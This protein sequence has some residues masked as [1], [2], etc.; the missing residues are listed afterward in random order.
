MGSRTCRLCGKPLSRIRVGSGDFCSREHHNQYHLRCGMDRMLEVNKVASLMRRCENP[1]PLALP[2]RLESSGV[3]QRGFFRPMTTEW[4]AG[5][6]PG[7]ALRRAAVRLT[8]AGS[9]FEFHPL[10]G[11][12]GRQARPERGA[13]ALVVPAQVGRAL[14]VSAAA[15]F[16]LP[17]MAAPQPK[18]AEAPF[19]PE[20]KPPGI[21]ARATPFSPVQPASAALRDCAIG[22]PRPEI[23]IPS[24]SSGLGSATRRFAGPRW[25][26]FVPAPAGFQT[27]PRVAAV[28]F[29]ASADVPSSLGAVGSVG[30]KEH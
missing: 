5:Q 23:R 6:R 2:S 19:S 18:T 9:A 24:V 17:K 29:T 13:R 28:R 3:P 10:E 21:K 15:G 30:S 7:G 25:L 16:R 14:R 11:P 8:V 12:D 4:A 22:M 20:L 27:F 1:K 26:G